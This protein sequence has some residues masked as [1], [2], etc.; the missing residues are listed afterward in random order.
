MNNFSIEYL[1]REALPTKIKYGFSETPFRKP[2]FVFDPQDRIIALGF[3]SEKEEE[4]MLL[5][6]KK[7][8]ISTEKDNPQAAEL[9]KKIFEN[10]DKVPVQVRL[11]GTDF[12]LSVWR[13][14]LNVP[15]GATA[16]YSAIASS[17]GKSAAVRAVAHAIATNP[18]A[19]IIPCHRIVPK[20]GQYGNYRWGKNL[21]IK[22]LEYEKRNT[23]P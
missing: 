10:S 1:N 23:R 5:E 3:I 7:Y 13:A 18:V 9:S 14:L 4:S 6:L 21:K 20:N 17:I 8:R 15:F 16:S 11:Y 22:I 2:F 19:W 12:Q